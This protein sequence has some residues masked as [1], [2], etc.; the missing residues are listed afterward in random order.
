MEFV[1]GETLR[2]RLGRPVTLELF[3]DIGMQCAD[4]LI[5][6]DQAA[7]VHGDIKP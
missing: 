7:V 3:L 5:G 4:A 2:E 6:A 1:E